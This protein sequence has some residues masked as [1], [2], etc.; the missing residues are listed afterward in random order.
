MNVVND[1]ILRL[2]G[3]QQT[4]GEIDYVNNEG[5]L[6]TGA[7]APAILVRAEGDLANLPNTYA[8]GSLAFTAGFK[9]MWQRNA[10][11]K[12]ISLT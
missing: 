10:E 3:R 2:I 6:H 12:W 5:E 7:N 1:A 8:P 4:S 11:G 9:Q